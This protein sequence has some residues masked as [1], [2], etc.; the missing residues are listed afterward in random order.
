M[1][2]V[3]KFESV[4]DHSWRMA[5]IALTFPDLPANVNRDLAVKMCIIH[6][7]PECK[8]GDLVTGVDIDEKSKHEKEKKR[9]ESFE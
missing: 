1:R 8:V 5:L 4:A 6:D 3:P 7:L 9:V 2:S